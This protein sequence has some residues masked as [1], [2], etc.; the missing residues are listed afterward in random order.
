MTMHWIVIT[1]A[2]LAGCGTAPEKHSPRPEQI[3]AISK[4]DIIALEYTS[5]A[6][7][8]ELLQERLLGESSPR[9]LADQRTNSLI[10]RGTPEE[11]RRVREWV[12]NIDKPVKRRRR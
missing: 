7:V 1:L 12:A 9:I 4:V 11:V 2:V 3:E 8:F 6:E 10:V 5:A